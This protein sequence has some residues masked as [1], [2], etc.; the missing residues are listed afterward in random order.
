VVQK[1][2]NWPLQVKKGSQ[3]ISQ[4][5]VV[6][7]LECSAIFQDFI[8]LLHSITVKEFENW[9]AFGEVNGQVYKVYILCVS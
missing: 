4:G 9:S 8:G 3:K 6:T 1:P 2:R 5:K 7:H